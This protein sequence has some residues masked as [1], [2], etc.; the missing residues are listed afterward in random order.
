MADVIVYPWHGLP[1]RYIDNGGVYSPQMTTVFDAD[2]PIVTNSNGVAERL[3]DNGDGTYSPV[4]TIGSDPSDALY[5]KNGLLQR[6]SSNGD[7]TYSRVIVLATLGG[8]DTTVF[9][10]YGL[11][12]RYAD[13]G[14]GTYA[15]IVDGTEAD[16]SVYNDYGLPVGFDS[17]SGGFAP[18]WDG[19]SSVYITDTNASANAVDEGATNGTVLPITLAVVNPPDGVTYSNWQITS[20]SVSGAFTINSSTG[21]ITVADGSLLDYE[22][23]ATHSIS[24]S[25]DG[26]DASVLTATLTIT[27]T[28]IAG[29]AGGDD[30]VILMM[31]SETEFTEYL[32]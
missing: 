25:V 5:T 32:Q 24:I 30:L 23:L 2:G 16:L 15:L 28:D 14:D 7:G 3:S 29:A 31:M 8:S 22:T 6:F 1:H 21:A 26:S 18:I 12:E 11:A 19:I 17:L 9:N 4:L 27:I 20:Q 13:L 10:E